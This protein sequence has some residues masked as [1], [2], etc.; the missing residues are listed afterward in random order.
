[1]TSERRIEYSNDS[2][3]LSINGRDFKNKDVYSVHS[4]KRYTVLYISFLV[5][6]VTLIDYINGYFLFKNTSFLGL[7]FG[8]IIRIFFLVINL[9]VLSTLSLKYLR[10][11]LF[12]I[13]F[14]LFS[15]T[16]MYLSNSGFSN[17]SGLS[18]VDTVKLYLNFLYVLVIILMLY[19]AI[20]AKLIKPEKMIDLGIWSALVAATLICVANLSNTGYLNYGFADNSRGYFS[21]INN[22]TVTLISGFGLTFYKFVKERRLRYLIKLIVILVPLFLIGTKSYIG[23]VLAVLLAYV[24]FQNKLKL[25]SIL[26]FLCIGIAVFLIYHQFSNSNQWLNIVSRWQYHYSHENSLLSFLLSSRNEYLILNI[27]AIKENLLVFV[28]GFPNGNYL[29]EMDFFDVIFYYGVLGITVDVLLIKWFL[30]LAKAMVVK[31]SNAILCATFLCLTFVSFFSGHVLFTIAGG[32]AYAVVVA[33]VI[34][35]YS[36][37]GLYEKV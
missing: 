21:A 11:C 35:D 8:Q 10:Y 29:T 9:F 6:T 34:S 37:R 24:L 16:I 4:V 32:S 14:F 5:S 25:K 30:R 3:A 2:G 18:I 12:A 33:V 22:T 7:S 20:T 36:K 26:I 28:L 27:P 1:M 15:F 23:G 17:R 19:R 31:K 13:L